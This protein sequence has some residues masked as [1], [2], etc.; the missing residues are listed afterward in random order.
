MLPVLMKQLLDVE[1]IGE[2][3]LNVRL[4]HMIP[5]NTPKPPV[6][7][8]GLFVIAFDG[9]SKFVTI[10]SEA[11]MIRTMGLEPI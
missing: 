4:R 11:P 8:S 10:R 9:K 7:P 2:E 5:E 1:P 3:R 6:Y